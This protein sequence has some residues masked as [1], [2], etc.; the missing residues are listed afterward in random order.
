[1]TYSQSSA[2]DRHPMDRIL[3]QHLIII[4]FIA[5][6][7][8]GLLFVYNLYSRNA[9]GRTDPIPVAPIVAPG[10]ERPAVLQRYP[11]SPSLIRVGIIPGHNGSDSGAVCDDGLQEVEITTDI[12]SKVIEELRQ[13]AIEV[14]NLLEYDDRLFGYDGDLLL[15]IHADS[16]TGPGSELSGFKSA[17]NNTP[18]SPMLQ[19]CIET[20]YSGA[21]GLGLNIN[22]ITNHMTQYHVFSKVN[23]TTPAIILE[24]G[25]MTRD[26]ELLTTNAEIPANAIVTGIMCFVENLP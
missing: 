11:Q 15:S 23:P 17:T 8:F 4:I 18:Q 26:R 2:E 22:T 12:A 24:T 9:E 20:A 10:E 25:F 13:R 19:Q 7:S 5:I 1:M 21:T 3:G 14:D 16:C 6:S